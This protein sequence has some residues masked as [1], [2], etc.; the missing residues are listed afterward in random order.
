MDFDLILNELSLRNPAPNEQVAQQRMSELIKTIK[1][2]KA[3][4]VKVSLRTKEDFHTIIL[5]PNYPLRHWLN[6]A[7][8]VERLFIKTLATKAPFSTNIANPE[9]QEIENN[10]SLSEFRHQGEIAIGLGIAYVLNTIT[11]NTIAI[12]LL[13][14]E[15][16][17]SNHVKLEF[18]C[19]DEYGEMISKIVEIIHASR[20]SHV[21]EH[22]SLIQQHQERIYQNVSDGLEVWNRREELFPNLEFC[23]VVRKQ[24]EDIRT[25]QLEL[26][27]V[28][29]ILFELH[30]CSKDWNNGY[31]NLDGYSVEESG[32]SKPTLDKY[33]KERTFRCPDGKDRLFDRHIKLRF[34]NWRI[35]FFAVKPGQVIIGYV[36]RHLPTVKHTT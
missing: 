28:V 10:V 7:D 22:T 24:L 31:F 13:S 36:G 33:F 21:Q 20:S 6:D 34:C 5:A 3:Q 26:Q 19:L 11:I 32:E 14:Q 29:S 12:S 35:H 1:A 16:W 2:V 23:D 4:G 9:I 17:D 25:G 15:C 18:R 27:P 8:Q 30:K